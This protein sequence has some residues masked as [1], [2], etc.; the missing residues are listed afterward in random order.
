MTIQN[1]ASGGDRNRKKTF[2]INR[3]YTAGVTACGSALVGIAGATER[4]EF[5]EL[6]ELGI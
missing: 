4:E 6:P 2:S 3:V 5:Q 1:E